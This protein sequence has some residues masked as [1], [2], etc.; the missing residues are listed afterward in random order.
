[1]ISI[2]IPAH[3]EAQVIGRLLAGL[4]RDVPSGEFDVVVV[5]NGCSDDTARIAASF[6]VRVIDTDRASKAEAL[7][8]GDQAARGFPRIYV[9]AD[10]ELGPDD[11][12]ALARVLTSSDVLAAGPVRELRTSGR[13]WAVR[14]Y[15]RVWERLPEVRRGLF[16]RG[17]VGVGERGYE[18]LAALPRVM[19]DDLAMSQAFAPGERTVVPDAKVVVHPPGTWQDLVRRRVRAATGVTQLES[20]GLDQAGGSARTRYADLLGM[21]RREPHLVGPLG[22]FV[23][24]ALVAKWRA[25]TADTSVWLRDESS[26]A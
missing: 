21:A 9:D 2:V 8:I 13:P 5:P 19:A 12:R 18:R 24:V 1:M 20:L 22:V 14:W 25:R 3:N 10:V 16:G 4:L 15:Y 26:R 7:R 23:T 6:P 17:V 11:I